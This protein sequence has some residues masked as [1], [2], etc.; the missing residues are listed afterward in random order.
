MDVYRGT[1][2]K[3][4]LSPDDLA[5][6][7]TWMQAEGPRQPTQGSRQSGAKNLPALLAEQ[8]AR[9]PVPATH[10]AQ[11]KIKQ[12]PVQRA[13]TRAVRRVSERRLGAVSRIATQLSNR[14]QPFNADVRMLK[15]R[16]RSVDERVA[17]DAARRLA[18]I[19]VTYGS[20]EALVPLLEKA[21]TASPVF[22]GFRGNTNEEIYRDMSEPIRRIAIEALRR[23]DV[24]CAQSLLDFIGGELSWMSGLGGPYDQVLGAVEKAMLRFGP[25]ALPVLFPALRR[26]ETAVSAARVLAKLDHME[27]ARALVDALT[28]RDEFVVAA[29]TRALI[30]VRNTSL[31][32]ALVR[33][34]QQGNVR[35]RQAA[36]DALGWMA[37][38]RSVEVLVAALGDEDWKVCA[39]AVVA[40]GRLNDRRAV[41]PLVALIAGSNPAMRLVAAGILGRLGD[42]RATAPLVG[43]LDDADILVRAAGAEALA[44]LGDPRAANPLARALERE[45]ED[46]SRLAMMTAL[47]K[48]KD[49]RA[50]EPLLQVLERKRGTLEQRPKAVELL[51]ELGDPH[52]IWPLATALVDKEPQVRRGAMVALER[53]D[54]ALAPAVPEARKRRKLSRYL[55]AARHND[56]GD[57]QVSVIA[58][59]LLAMLNAQGTANEREEE[60]EE[61]EDELE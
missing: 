40:L 13:L 32:D 43:L 10:A 15:E 36:A 30:G 38:R 60:D 52:A 31:L 51:G 47:V 20:E 19:S 61:D 4:A 58:R 24:R 12:P 2:P 54:I 45:W 6:E 22:V 37:D 21:A 46:R 1:T 48:L 49:S 35:M 42:R 17:A 14:I 41:T 53:I 44:S 29:V 5:G 23:I 34:I 11:I 55:R 18:E 26:N 50:L 3:P 8:E 27:S 57:R 56:D 33:A 28:S 25:D 16:L 7:E 59:Q 39:N 9:V